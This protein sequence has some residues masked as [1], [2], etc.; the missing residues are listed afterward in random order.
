[1]NLHKILF[2]KKEAK[3]NYYKKATDK[4]V[5]ESADLG[6]HLMGELFLPEDLEFTLTK[7]TDEEV[8]EMEIYSKEG[9]NITPSH[10][11]LHQWSVVT[12]QGKSIAVKIDSMYDAIVIFKAMGMKISIDTIMNKTETIDKINDMVKIEGE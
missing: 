11:V 12:Q 6:H 3:L 7:T 9:F 2:P 10:D 1:M 8:G 4:L 5:K